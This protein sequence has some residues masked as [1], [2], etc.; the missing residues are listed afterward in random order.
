[1]QTNIHPFE[2]YPF[3]VKKLPADIRREVEHFDF[4]TTSRAIEK[5]IVSDNLSDSNTLLCWAYFVWIDAMAM[6]TGAEILSSGE[7]ALKIIAEIL[8]KEPGHKPSLK[9]QKFINDEIKKV[10]K[11]NKW[12]DKF[13]N[14]PIE[15]LS[16]KEAEDFAFFLSDCTN[17]EKFKEKEYQLWLRLYN[18]KPDVYSTG[19]KEFYGFKFYYLCRISNVLWRDLKRFEEARPLLWQIINW[20]SVKD[21]E[22][23][24]YNIS[25][26]VQLLILEA[27]DKRD[28]IEFARL[29]ELMISKFGE[30]NQYRAG[31]G[32]GELTLVLREIPA[33]KILQFALE[34]GDLKNI[35]LIMDHFFAGEVV[36]IRDGRIKENMKKA[37]ALIS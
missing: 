30:I 19:V 11:A 17:E 13:H 34:I 10:H 15:S 23:Y 25:N 12:Y 8:G 18:E 5:S 2:K 27:V 37:K 35:R 32:K 9:L 31:L 4:Y 26:A 24:S 16:L 1:M 33:G 7:S 21:A 28:E 14:I 36:L 29:T 20:P 6:Q 22:L 3:D